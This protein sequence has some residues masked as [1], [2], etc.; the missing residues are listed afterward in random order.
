MKKNTPLGKVNI[1]LYA[2][3][4]ELLNQHQNNRF[5]N[6][7]LEYSEKDYSYINDALDEVAINYFDKEP[8]GDRQT[9][10]LLTRKI[11]RHP[12]LTDQEAYSLILDRF[13]NT[14]L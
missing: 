6:K 11:G 3:L 1:K 8:D 2:A 9:E 12:L 14:E 10:L 5:D 7:G 4:L 13:N